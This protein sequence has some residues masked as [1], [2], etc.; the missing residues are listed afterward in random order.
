VKPILPDGCCYSANDCLTGECVYTSCNLDVNQ[1][2]YIEICP[3]SGLNVTKKACLNDNQCQ[4]ANPCSLSKCIDNFCQSSPLTNPTNPLCC[5][6]A[7]D[8]ALSP[9]TERFCDYRSY[10]CFYVPILGCDISF[11]DT[12]IPYYPSTSSSSSTG[13]SPDAELYVIPDNPDAGDIFFTIIGSIILFIV[14]LLFIIA[15]LYCIYDNFFANKDGGNADALG[16]A[17]A[18]GHTEHSHGK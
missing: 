11:G 8:C 6:N 18:A 4:G 14:V 12:I 15:L 9:C 3:N 5:Q 17:A 7:N 1:W 13:L 10:T 2:E 16:E